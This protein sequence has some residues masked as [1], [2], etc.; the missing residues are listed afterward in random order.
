MTLCALGK[1]ATTV[2][3]QIQVA[4]ADGWATFHGGVPDGSDLECCK[5]PH[6]AS[7]AEFWSHKLGQPIPDGR[8]LI[9]ERSVPKENQLANK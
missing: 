9:W 5:L 2:H 3:I 8:A 1:G 4:L 6:Q 7:R